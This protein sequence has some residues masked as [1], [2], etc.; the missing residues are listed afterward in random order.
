MGDD[1]ADW[2]PQVFCGH[3]LTHSSGNFGDGSSSSPAALARRSQCIHRR[4]SL[5]KTAVLQHVRCFHLVL[6]CFASRRLA[7]LQ[8]MPRKV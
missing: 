2:T 7:W 3:L 1:D 4:P 6:L 5:A 8:R